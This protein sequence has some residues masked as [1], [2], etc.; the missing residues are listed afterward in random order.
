MRFEFWT[1]SNGTPLMLARGIPAKRH[2]ASGLIDFARLSLYASSP[3][4]VKGGPPTDL[5]M[6]PKISGPFQNPDRSG[7]P[8]AVRGVGFA[9]PEGAAMG[10]DAPANSLYGFSGGGVD[11][12]AVDGCTE[13]NTTRRL[14]TKRNRMCVN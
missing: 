5:N 1:I 8:S 3:A 7:L 10:P 6:P 2:N 11:C 9:G 12:A 4:G 14:H 13:I